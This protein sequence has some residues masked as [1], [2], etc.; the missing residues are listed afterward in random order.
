MAEDKYI[1]QGAEDELAREL[2]KRGYN[3]VASYAIVPPEATDEAAV[4]AV[5][6]K[7]GAK[8]VVAMRPV[9]TDQEVSA[10]SVS[11]YSGWG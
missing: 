8:A 1:R 2:T 11:V 10:T 5:F 3:G 6:E 7:M 9:A 4:R